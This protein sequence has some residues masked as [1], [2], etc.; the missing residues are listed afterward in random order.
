MTGLLSLLFIFWI[1]FLESPLFH[2]IDPVTLETVK[3]LSLVDS[4]NLPKGLK[5]LVVTAHGH[6]DQN[7]DYWNMG[8]ALDT[9]GLVP[10]IVYF[11]YYIRNVGGKFGKTLNAKIN[12][13]V[14]L[15]KIEFSNSFAENLNPMDT[16]AR[17]FH[18]F[19]GTADYL[20]Q[21]IMTFLCFLAFFD[22]Q[23]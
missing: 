5:I 20:G 7:G 18:M 17:Y 16:N 1:L 8:S 10:K 15:D 12:P 21:Q 4:P 23:L 6:I 11:T 19:S 2:L 9:R 3:S 13:D 14:F 22:K